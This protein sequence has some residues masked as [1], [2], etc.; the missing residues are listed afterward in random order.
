MGH[1]ENGREDP[2]RQQEGEH[3]L[4][5]DGLY[6]KLRNP[7]CIVSRQP[8][9][10]CGNDFDPS[11]RQVL[12]GQRYFIESLTRG[13]ISWVENELVNVSDSFWRV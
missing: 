1:R 8:T 6:L 12:Q 13:V 4:L 7:R 9:I 11:N 5:L 10:S 3:S 2:S